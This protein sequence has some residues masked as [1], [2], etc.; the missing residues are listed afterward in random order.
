M[1]K[2]QLSGLIAESSV[3]ARATQGWGASNVQLT[4]TLSFSAVPAGILGAP[5]GDVLVGRKRLPVQ[6]A[7]RCRAVGRIGWI[8]ADF[9]GGLGE[10][11][12]VAWDDGIVVLGPVYTHNHGQ[13]VAHIRDWAINQA[14]RHFGVIARAGMDEFDTVRLGR[15]GRGKD[16]DR[17][18]WPRAR[19]AQP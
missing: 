5:G 11:W 9:I 6:V 7:E 19:A 10:Q 15:L 2:F 18:A 17:Y 14:L 12:A 8:N 3:L 13:H 16:P 4:P 1:I